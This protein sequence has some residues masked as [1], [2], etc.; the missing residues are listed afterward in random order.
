MFDELER[1]RTCE[2]LVRLLNHYA[3][4]GQVDRSIWQ[5]R[6]M[7]LD[8]VLTAELTRLHGELI[9]FDWIEMNVGFTTGK[10]PETVA[11]CYRITLAGVRALKRAQETEGEEEQPRL[12]RFTPL[13][14]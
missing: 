9:A 5:D 7:E 13:A 11:S 6:L 2:V 4:L 10:R 3:E 1:L 8:G 14:G 12:F